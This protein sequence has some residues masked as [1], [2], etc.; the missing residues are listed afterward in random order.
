VDHRSTI[1]LIGAGNM[2]EALIRGLLGRGVVPGEHLWVTNRT[3]TAR[4]ESLA[5]RYGIRIA[6]DKRPVAAASSTLLLAVKPKDMAQV[7]V[8][9]RGL[10]HADHLI[11]SVAAG[12]P[13]GMIE[14]AL[15]AVP[16]IRA[17][18]NT[19]AAV[20]E[21]ATVL[22]AGTRA[23]EEHMREA[24]RIFQAVGEVAVVDEDLLD[25][26]TAVSGSGPAYVYHLIEAMIHAGSELGLDGDLARR[27]AVQT[28]VGAARML[29]ETSEDP[30]DLRRRV[31]S[32]GGTTMAALQ[33]L[34]ARGFAQTVREAVD[35]AARRSR[36]LASEFGGD[37]ATPAWT[38]ESSR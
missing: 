34:E 4:L 21:S 7:L 31:T 30:G 29:S 36:E 37:G 13:L 19:S 35:R 22:A 18:P 9:I 17:M 11:V 26:V 3:N 32:P 1:G 8:E 12:I 33:A 38:P 24:S 5:A 23:G 6:R 20:Q 27:L 25:V 16:V 28:L 15:P 10:V 2:A 14:E